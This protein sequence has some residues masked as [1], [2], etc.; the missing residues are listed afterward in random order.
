MSG[1]TIVLRLTSNG[2]VIYW[3]LPIHSIPTILDIH[4]FD[5]G[6]GGKDKSKVDFEILKKNSGVLCFHMVMND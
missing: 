6:Y 3:I 5:Y 2:G 1:V 4:C